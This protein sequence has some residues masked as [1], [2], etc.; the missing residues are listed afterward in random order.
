MQ[1]R[2]VQD[3]MTSNVDAAPRQPG[4]NTLTRNAIRARN[5]RNTMLVMQ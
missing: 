4:F 2:S 3:H 1:I 5:A